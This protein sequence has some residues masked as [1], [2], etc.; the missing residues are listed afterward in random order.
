VYAAELGEVG[1]TEAGLVFLGRHGWASEDDVGRAGTDRRT[2]AWL[3]KV[4]PGAVGLDRP[5][6]NGNTG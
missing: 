2:G 5:V 4:R 1:W 6:G 3:G